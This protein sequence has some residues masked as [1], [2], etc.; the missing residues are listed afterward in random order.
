MIVIKSLVKETIPITQASGRQLLLLM[1][2]LVLIVQIQG[3]Q[4][5]ISVKSFIVVMRMLMDGLVMEVKVN[6]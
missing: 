2:K 5:S 6:G 4:Q 1:K 3:V